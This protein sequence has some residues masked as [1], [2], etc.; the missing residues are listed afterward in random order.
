MVAGCRTLTAKIGKLRRFFSSESI[1][2]ISA[3]KESS[4][5]F[6]DYPDAFS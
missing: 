1:S 5:G 4:S 2:I 6:A 3:P